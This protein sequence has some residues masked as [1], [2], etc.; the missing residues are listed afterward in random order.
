M[1]QEIETRQV[2]L[3][4]EHAASTEKSRWTILYKIDRSLYAITSF[5]YAYFACWKRRVCDKKTCL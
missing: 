1:N 5:Y 4:A 2:S 3:P